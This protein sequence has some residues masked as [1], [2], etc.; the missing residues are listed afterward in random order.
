MNSVPGQRP[1]ARSLSCLPRRLH[2]GGA[3]ANLIDP[4]STASSDADR[5]MPPGHGWGHAKG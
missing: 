4:A 5:P 2:P 1:G 3:G